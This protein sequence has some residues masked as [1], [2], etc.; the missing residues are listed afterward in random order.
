RTTGFQ[1]NGISTA[2]NDYFQTT[3]SAASGFTLSLSTI[4]ARFAGTSTYAAAP[5]VMSQFAYSLDGNNFTLIGSPTTTI[6]TPVMMTQINLSAINDLQNVPDTTT[7]YFR[8][9]ASGQTATGGWGFNSPSAGQ[10]GLAF[11]GTLTA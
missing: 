11:G 3:L 9:Y 1:N 2:N 10:E 5:G 6:G 7:V 4:D 8:Y